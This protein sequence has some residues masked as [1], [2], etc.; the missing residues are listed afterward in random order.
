MTAETQATG[1][2]MLDATGLKCPLPVLRARRALKVMA[3]GERL[4]VRATD[5]AA[6]KDFAAFCAMTGDVLEASTEEGDI[7]I[8][9]IRKQA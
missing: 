6:P 7:F 8:F 4:I 2:H 5:P 9:H 1:D 3:V